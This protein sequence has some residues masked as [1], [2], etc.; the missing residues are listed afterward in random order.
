MGPRGSRLQRV[1][2]LAQGVVL[3]VNVG[4]PRPVER[5]GTPA[6]TAIWKSPVAGRVAARGVN[7]AGDDQ[8]DRAVH[9]GY[10]KA[11]YAY[12]I[13]D[14]RWWE[15]ER[16]RAIGPGGFGENLTVEGLDLVASVVGERWNVG[17]A[18]LEVSE[19]RLPCW[20]LGLR[21]GDPSFPQRFTRAARPGAY[22]RIV[23]EGDIGAGDAVRVVSR[24]DHGFTVGDIWRV[25][26]RDRREATALLEVPELGESWR[27]WAEGR[28]QR[29]SES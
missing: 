17:T 7:L 20:K 11:V 13:E 22:L 6:S 23:D 2:S 3:S 29:M 1:V 26:H 19:P 8:A 9:G 15:A 5:D 18:L 10:D 4:G 27:Q 25:Y 21:M 12:S 14:T 16:G 28:V 24:P